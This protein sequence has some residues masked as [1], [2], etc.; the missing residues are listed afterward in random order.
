MAWRQGRGKELPGWRGQGHYRVQPEQRIRIIW[1]STQPGPN[2][3]PP[4]EIALAPISLVLCEN[5][6]KAPE[7]ADAPSTLRQAISEAAVEISRAKIS[8]STAV[9]RGGR[10][11][12]NKVRRVVAT[13]FNHGIGTASVA[14]DFCII[15]GR[16]SDCVDIREPAAAEVISLRTWRRGISRIVRTLRREADSLPGVN[17][18]RSVA[19]N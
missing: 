14:K 15:G 9:V 18:P 16:W 10:S 5:G 13:G 11:D 4:G 7:S 12:A 3:L 2:A 1:W 19:R 8:D 17:R 6:R